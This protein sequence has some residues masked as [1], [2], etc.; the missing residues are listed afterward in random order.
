MIWAAFL[1]G[2]AGSLHCVG[3]CSPLATAVTGLSRAAA[4]NR[5]LYNGGR[6][7]T[8]GILGAAVGAFGELA[9]LTDYQ[10]LLSA[11]LGAILI[12]LG[13]SGVSMIRIPVVTDLLQG[14]TSWLK[15]MF[16]SH[17]KSRSGL[18]LVV[19]GGING[20]L[21]CGLTYFALTYCITLP[22]A[23]D[24]F[25]FMAAFG[26]G[27]LPVMLGIPSVL[28]WL[29][30]RLQWRVQHITAAVMIALG[31]LLIARSAYFVQHEHAPTAEATEVVCP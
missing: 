4:I 26:L 14:F 15:K 25:L 29:S 28:H 18:S 11:G 17:V 23:G 30:T 3:M 6:I 21:P 9:G 12:L 22:N 13:L 20:L 31:A 1:I 2:L 10:L 16:A 24:G 19:M 5:L 27:T 7:L 8:Y